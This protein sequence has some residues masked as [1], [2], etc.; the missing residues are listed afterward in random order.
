[1]DILQQAPNKRAW[2]KSC[3]IMVKHSIWDTHKVLHIY[4][5]FQL[6]VDPCL[7][8]KTGIKLRGKWVFL[9]KLMS[10]K[11]CALAFVWKGLGSRHTACRKPY[12]QKCLILYQGRRNIRGLG[13]WTQ[14]ISCRYI[15]HIMIRGRE[16][17]PTPLACP[18]QILLHSGPPVTGGDCHFPRRPNDLGP[19]TTKDTKNNIYPALASKIFTLH[20]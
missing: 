6:F 20:Y 4:L 7:L 14:P 5:Q 16:I 2:S 13:E 8:Y 9:T 12:T 19:K 18:H 3:S 15:N 17:K 1:M 10:S 11:Q